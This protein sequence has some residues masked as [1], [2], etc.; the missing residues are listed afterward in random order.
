MV[1]G[2]ACIWG[3][4]VDSSNFLPRTWPRAGAVGERLW[5]KTDF[6]NLKSASTRIHNHRCRLIVYVAIINKGYTVNSLDIAMFPRDLS[7]LLKELAVVL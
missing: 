1:G 5:S 3:E 6:S 2:E 4:Y 7:V